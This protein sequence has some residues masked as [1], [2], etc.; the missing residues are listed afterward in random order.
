LLNHIRDL[1]FLITADFR[2]KKQLSGG[3]LFRYFGC[4]LLLQCLQ[5]NTKFYFFWGPRTYNIYVKLKD[6][7]RPLNEKNDHNAK[8]GIKE[9]AITRNFAL[10]NLQ[11]RQWGFRTES[12]LQPLS[13]KVT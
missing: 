2:R 3:N 9:T 1:S 7:K 12:H 4:V 11:W 5:F 6:R 8:C 13:E 10:W